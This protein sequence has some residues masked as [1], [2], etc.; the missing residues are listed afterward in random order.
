VPA[1]GVVKA[2]DVVGHIWGLTEFAI[3]HTCKCLSELL[4]GRAV[5]MGVSRSKV[6][7]KAKA[8]ATD[9]EYAIVLKPSSGKCFLKFDKHLHAL[10]EDIDDPDHQMLVCDTLLALG[11]SERKMYCNDDDGSQEHH[12][13]STKTMRKLAKEYLYSTKHW[14]D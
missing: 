7:A 13:S 6:M 12:Y 5:L 8:T 10:L 3:F 14:F 1:F 2:L 4:A 11:L 9:H